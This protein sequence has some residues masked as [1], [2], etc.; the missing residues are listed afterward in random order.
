MAKKFIDPRT[1][2]AEIRANEKDWFV[3]AKTLSE[4]KSYLKTKYDAG[5]KRFVV[6]TIWDPETMKKPKKKYSDDFSAMITDIGKY[7]GRLKKKAVAVEK[8]LDSKAWDKLKLA[9]E[10]LWP[11]IVGLTLPQGY[12]LIRTKVRTNSSQLMGLPKRLQFWEVSTAN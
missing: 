6:E 7:Y 9:V 8:T 5:I 10:S 2:D 3:R 4:I 11:E 1:I 12:E